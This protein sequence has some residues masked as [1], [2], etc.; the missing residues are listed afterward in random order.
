[1]AVELRKRAL[2]HAK[3]LFHVLKKITNTNRL[4]KP[5]GLVGPKF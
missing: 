3:A 5:H 1:M 4:L 2:T